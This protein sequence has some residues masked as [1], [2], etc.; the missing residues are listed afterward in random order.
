M[1]IELPVLDDKTY[2]ELLEEAR[3]SLPAIYPGW[4]DHN[5]SDPGIALIELF[6]WLTEMLVYR[7]GRIPEQSERMF[8][9][10]LRGSDQGNPEEPLELA[11]LATLRALRE[12]YR[13]VT[14]EDYE[15]L[16]MHAW[17]GSERALL[18]EKS[19]AGSS[20]IARAHGLAERDLT[21]AG[22]TDPAPGHVSVIVLPA[23]SP[24]PSSLLQDLRAFLLE[25]C[26]ITTCLHVVE[27]AWVP[28]ELTATL[29]LRD[30]A[31]AAGAGVREAALA[32]LR[33][34]LHPLT[35]GPARRGWP[36]GRDVDISDISAVLD[37]VP[38]VEFVEAVELT[39]G[40][41]AVKDDR[42]NLLGLRIDAHELPRI[43]PGAIRLTLKERQGGQWKTI[44]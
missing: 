17:P 2:A 7:T 11:A 6:A 44:P 13:A 21:A 38:G 28:V 12:R 36:F 10:L 42:G 19:A 14:P 25:R 27:P 8:L 35:G 41:R 43:D 4:T 1:A 16:A 9:R 22:K 20:R 29:C 31:P 18:L 39:V 3:A 23:G 26:L 37:D 15:L 34:H 33:E 32:A 24:P 40:D 30:D 5:P